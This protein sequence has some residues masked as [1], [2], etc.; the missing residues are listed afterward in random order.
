MSIF[1]SNVEAAFLLPTFIRMFWNFFSEASK[2]HICYV[3]QMNLNLWD[4]CCGCRRVWKSWVPFWGCS[5]PEFSLVCGSKHTWVFPSLPACEDK[6]GFT[7]T[8]CKYGLINT[9]FP[10]AP[11][12]HLLIRKYQCLANFPSPGIWGV[13]RAALQ[14]S[15]DQTHS[16]LAV[17]ASQVRS[18]NVQVLNLLGGLRSGV[19]TPAI[20][21][22]AASVWLS[23]RLAASVEL[24]MT[25]QRYVTSAPMRQSCSCCF[26]NLI[27]V[28]HL[29]SAPIQPPSRW[30]EDSVPQQG[31]LGTKV[32]RGWRNQQFPLPLTALLPC[33]V[34][35]TTGGLS[36]QKS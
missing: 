28:A 7:N 36:S 25:L 18:L 1:D 29:I 5:N 17:A 3:F 9:G 15:V 4:H 11:S 10:L 32:P 33:W 35:H 14:V 22:S 12:F 6:R 19:I 20:A 26:Q 21:A 23:Q 13:L 24:S 34:H 16:R 31:C 8:D 27:L 2:R 30:K